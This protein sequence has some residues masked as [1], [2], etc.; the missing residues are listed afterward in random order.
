[1]VGRQGREID[2]SGTQTFFQ[3][4][5]PLSPKAP[6]TYSPLPAQMK[7]AATHKL[8]V[9][10]LP[11]GALL[12]GKVCPVCKDSSFMGAAISSCNMARL[13]G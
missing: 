12:Q 11:K 8:W 10:A 3:E 13:A 4:I 2:L 6:S 5:T 9:T 1:M 7:D